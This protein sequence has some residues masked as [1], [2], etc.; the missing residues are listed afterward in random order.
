MKFKSTFIKLF[1]KLIK[2]DRNLKIFKNGVDNNYAELVEDAIDNSVTATRCAELVADCISGQGFGDELNNLI[3]HE[4]K[5]TTLLQFA[6][7][8]AESFSRQKGVYI[9][10]NFD[11]NFKIKDMDVQ[12]FVDCRVGKKDDD[13][14]NG[15][16]LVCSDWTDKNVSKK[17]REVDVYNYKENVIKSQVNKAGSIDKYNGQMFYFK[18][19]KYIYPLSPI[20]PALNDAESEAEASVYKHTSL[21]KGFFGKT[22]VVTKPLVDDMLEDSDP[23]TYNQQ[24]SERDQ[25]KKTIK[26]FMGASNADGVLH[27]EMEFESDDLE[28][29]FVVKQIESNIDDKLFAHTEDS[30]A[31]NICV[32]FRVPQILVRPKDSSLFASSGELITQAKI[33]LQEQTVNERMILEQIVNKLM[34]NFKEPKKDL[35]IKPLIDV[36]NQTGN[37]DSQGDI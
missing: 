15:K 5:E 18:F 31:N 19:G 25:F 21:K 28:K 6:Q 20:H 36:D 17:A 24:M 1:G 23:D 34:A 13:S 4:E 10:C 22:L 14:H 2:Y 11:G 29:E 8:I 27:I 7:D 30:V 33:F 26:Q 3:V 37:S 12:S 16:I 32:A 35:K 9:H